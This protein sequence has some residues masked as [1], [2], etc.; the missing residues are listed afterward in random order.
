M[1]EVNQ[2]N[3]VSALIGRLQKCQINKQIS[4]M[5]KLEKHMEYLILKSIFSK[6]K[7]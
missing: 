5:K 7:K 1:A 4:K 2:T 6:K 3:E